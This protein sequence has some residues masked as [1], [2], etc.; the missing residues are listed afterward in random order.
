MLNYYTLPISFE[1]H[2]IK[3][4]INEDHC[5]ND[6]QLACLRPVKR[7]QYDVNAFEEHRTRIALRRP[8]II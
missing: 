8:S 6:Y 1:Y 5:Q 2:Y 4:Q 7:Q 3:G